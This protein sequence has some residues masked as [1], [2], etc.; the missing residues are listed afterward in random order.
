MALDTKE[1]ILIAALELFAARGRVAVGT[2]AIAES[3]GVNEA[4]LFRTFG[5]KD[6]LWVEV[7]Q[8]FV[9]LPEPKF[10]LKGTTGSLAQDLELFVH[11]IIELLKANTKLVRMGMMDKGQFPEIDA[12]LDSQPN[13]MILILTGHLE[14]HQSELKAA[15]EVVARTLVDTLF[16]VAIHFE[17]FHQSPDSTLNRWAAEFLPLFLGG[18][19]Q[20]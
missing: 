9:V 8:R 15:P 2:K 17:V 1:K 5:T 20:T 16:G 13:Q 3:A 6:R 18:C 14:P 4:T 10:L 7:F 12:E 11:H 19:L